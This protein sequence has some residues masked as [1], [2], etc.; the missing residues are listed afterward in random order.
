MLPNENVK[1]NYDYCVKIMKVAISYKICK[2]FW[3]KSGNRWGGSF[4]VFTSPPQP[5]SAIFGSH[6]ETA[7]IKT[8]LDFDPAAGGNAAERQIYSKFKHRG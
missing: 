2:F 3:Q 4:E 7:E 5:F 6:G 8:S 1:I